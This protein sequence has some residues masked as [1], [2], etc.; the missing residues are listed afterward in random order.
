MVEQYSIS[1]SGIR[2]RLDQPLQQ[3]ICR[4]TQKEYN[5][6]IYVD[7]LAIRKSGSQRTSLSE[8]NSVGK[9]PG[10]MYFA[11]PTNEYICEAEEGVNNSL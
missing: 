11:W 7:W 9:Y 3:W 6:A 5:D 4:V 8:Q 2:E 10:I 1:V